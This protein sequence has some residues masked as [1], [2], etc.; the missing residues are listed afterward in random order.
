MKLL[1]LKSI[2]VNTL[3]VL[4]ARGTLTTAAGVKTCRRGHA[5]PPCWRRREVRRAKENLQVS[6]HLPVTSQSQVLPD[7][8][9]WT[10]LV[11]G[12]IFKTGERS[13]YK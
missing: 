3:P 13:N 6:M 7:V 5:A 4:I 10:Q 11:Y 1:T 2:A 12:F 9:T 8:T